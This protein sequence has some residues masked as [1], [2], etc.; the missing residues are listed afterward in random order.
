MRDTYLRACF[1]VVQQG[2]K[3]ILG[4]DGLEG[5]KNLFP[6]TSTHASHHALKEQYISLAQPCWDIMIHN[7]YPYG[8]LLSL[9][10]PSLL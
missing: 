8:F 6:F 2:S 5:G 7:Q 3:L 10:T 1:L 9:E 4:G